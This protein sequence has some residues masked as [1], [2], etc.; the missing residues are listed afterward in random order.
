MLQAI[1]VSQGNFYGK[2]HLLPWIA[3][4]L[5][6]SRL[7]FR[8]KR[9]Y[10]PVRLA[11][12]MTINKSEGQTLDTVGLYLPNLFFT[13]VQ[14]YVDLSRM[15]IGPKGIVFCEGSANQCS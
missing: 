1:I 11:F 15:R 4:Y 6:Q 9:L 12:T 8:F 14:L 2:V 7:L 13:H 5:S 3:L 10:F